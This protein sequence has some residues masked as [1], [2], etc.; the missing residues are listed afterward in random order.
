MV[1]PQEIKN[2]MYEITSNYSP[3][4]KDIEKQIVSLYNTIINEVKNFNV[5]EDYDC[6][7][8]RF[9]NSVD[10]DYII[11]FTDILDF[12][13]RCLIHQIYLSIDNVDE[14]NIEF[15]CIKK[16]P[17]AKRKYFEVAKNISKKTI[18]MYFY[19]PYLEKKIISYVD[20]FLPD[21]YTKY[22]EIDQIVWYFLVCITSFNQSLV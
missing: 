2:K 9:R 8:K 13:A 10:Q 11:V 20:D 1:I 5:K 19:N 15:D 16:A 4:K 14:I 17:S 6:I 12:T 21:K 7:Y 18:K 22:S 3:D